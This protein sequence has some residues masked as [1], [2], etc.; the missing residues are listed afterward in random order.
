[1]TLNNSFKHRLS[2]NFCF[3]LQVRIV[4]VPSMSWNPPNQTVAVT[5]GAKRLLFYACLHP[6]EASVYIFPIWLSTCHVM[7]KTRSWT[8]LLF[9]KHLTIRLQ[10]PKG[11]E[12]LHLCLLASSGSR[13]LYL[14]FGWLYAMSSWKLDLEAIYHPRNIRQ[15]E[16]CSLLQLHEQLVQM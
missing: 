11:K 2:S 12:A 5:C 15:F 8:H 10:L 4:C 14:L 16:R 13:C 6:Q 1:M 3:Q 9:K 7:L